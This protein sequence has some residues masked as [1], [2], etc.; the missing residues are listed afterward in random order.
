MNLFCFQEDIVA[1]G[2]VLVGLL[3]VV[4]PFLIFCV[5]INTNNPVVTNPVVTVQPECYDIDVSFQ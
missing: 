5:C 4:L 2:V 3:A 1:A